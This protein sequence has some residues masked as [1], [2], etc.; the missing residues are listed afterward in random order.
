M[1]KRA[2]ILG[3]LAV[4]ALAPAA[5]AQTAD[6]TGTWTATFETN[7]QTYPATLILKTDADKASGTISSERGEFAIDGRVSGQTVTFSFTMQGENGPIAIAMKG[8]AAGDAM[9]GTFD[10]GGGEGTGTWSAHRGDA[11]GKEPPQEA[12]PAAPVDV[13]GTWA[14]SLE[15][16]NISATPT[17]V[18]KQDG[19]SLTGEY[20]SQQYGRFPLKGR[21]KDNRIDFG[22]EMSIDGNA[23]SVSYSG[24]VVD[25]DT[26]KGDASYGGLAD[27][28][29]TASRS[30]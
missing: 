15:L 11:Q 24:T 9:K 4:V 16:P 14:F 27:G 19:Q 25:K 21:L 8:E 18:L 23:I 10:H 7:G 3:I 28:T 5:W 6:I 26:I 13:T 30:K 2:I 17:I 12:A 20:Q 1:T 29:F 22:F